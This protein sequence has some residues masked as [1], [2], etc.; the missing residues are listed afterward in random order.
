MFAVR[1]QGLI[2]GMP[3]SASVR[4]DLINHGR[5]A[6]KMW[7][8]K[9]LFLIYFLVRLL[10]FTSCSFIFV[11]ICFFLLL[12]LSSLF[13]YRLLS[14][15]SGGIDPFILNIGARWGERSVSGPSRFIFW[16]M[17]SRYPNGESKTIP[18]LYSPRRRQCSDWA[19]QALLTLLPWDMC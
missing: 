18:R 2:A 7:R 11:S 6:W 1:L 12:V 19:V 9:S 13:I 4:T 14:M 5:S 15:G 10:S 8:L 3:S 17:A 16:G